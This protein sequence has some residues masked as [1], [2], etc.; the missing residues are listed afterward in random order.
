M[1]PIEFLEK[2]LVENNNNNRHQILLICNNRH[3][4]TKHESN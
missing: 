3:W 4:P 2:F 1:A